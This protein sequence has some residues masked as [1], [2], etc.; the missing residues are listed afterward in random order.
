M[1]KQYENHTGLSLF[2]V[3]S[4]N[5]GFIW[6]EDARHIEIIKNNQKKIKMDGT[7]FNMII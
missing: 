3:G 1:R 7:V 2:L 6:V 5:E 4:Q